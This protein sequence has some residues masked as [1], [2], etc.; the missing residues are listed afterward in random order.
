MLETHV[1]EQPFMRHHATVLCRGYDRFGDGEC[2]K[3]SREHGRCSAEHVAREL[4]EENDGCYRAFRE[5][6]PGGESSG[7]C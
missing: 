6:K 2:E 1:H 7:V 4:V 3:V 5:G